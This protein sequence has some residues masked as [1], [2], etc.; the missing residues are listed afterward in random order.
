M[1]C[2]GR[3]EG[4]LMNCSH[5][6]GSLN[7]LVRKGWISFRIREDVKQ[8]NVMTPRLFTLSMD[9]KMKAKMLVVLGAEMCIDDVER[10][11]N[12]N[13]CI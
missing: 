9:G 4:C 3:V 1:G 7:V 12:T 8:C 10:K 5:F 6:T 11:L 13:L 2:V